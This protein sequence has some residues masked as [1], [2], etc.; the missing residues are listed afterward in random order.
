[1]SIAWQLEINGIKLFKKLS[2]TEAQCNICVDPFGKPKKY[3][4]PGRTP[5]VLVPHISKHTDYKKQYDELKAIEDKKKEMEKQAQMSIQKFTSNG[6][7]LNC[8]NYVLFRYSFGRLQS[9]KL[10]LQNESA[11]LSCRRRDFQ[12]D[13]QCFRV[14]KP[15]L[16][17]RHSIAKRL[18]HRQK[19]NYA[20]VGSI[21]SFI[22][23]V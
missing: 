6:K 23:H 21:R 9:N 3:K 10:H 8:L 15:S 17:R 2:S 4:L 14:K 13:L 19:S 11:F 18:Q 7:L 22:I 16:L 12:D 5:S 1:M 20:K